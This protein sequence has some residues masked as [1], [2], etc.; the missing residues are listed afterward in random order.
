MLTIKNAKILTFS[1]FYH[2]NQEA[3]EKEGFSHGSKGLCPYSSY[4]SLHEEVVVHLF[5]QMD[6]RV[7]FCQ[8]ERKEIFPSL[9]A[10]CDL[11][12]VLVQGTC[13]AWIP[14]CRTSVHLDICLEWMAFDH[15]FRNNLG[16]CHETVAFDHSCLTSCC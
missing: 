10:S 5:Y 6:S 11:L 8:A 2:N 9:E 13:L 4:L 16:S 14:S 1:Y 7:S 15:P 3:S 12:V